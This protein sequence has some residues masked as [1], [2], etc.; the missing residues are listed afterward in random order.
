MVSSISSS[1]L[2]A[3]S[4]RSAAKFSRAQRS[5]S[6]LTWQTGRKLPRSTRIVFL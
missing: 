5:M 2:T 1:D 6:M 4:P 3:V